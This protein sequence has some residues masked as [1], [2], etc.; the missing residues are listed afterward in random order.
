MW[1]CV[2]L[3]SLLG[4]KRMT[5][6]DFCDLRFYHEETFDIRSNFVDNMNN[7]CCDSI[8]LDISKYD[9]RQTE[10]KQIFSEN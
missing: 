2:F 9:V 6:L 10:H 1:A 5:T 8:I 3:L 7:E 4:T